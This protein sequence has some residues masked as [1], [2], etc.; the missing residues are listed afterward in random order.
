M[1]IQGINAVLNLN[2]QIAPDVPYSLE[3]AQVS[4]IL[5]K[6][7]SKATE[8]I[9]G[10]IID[11]AAGQAQVLLTPQTLSEGGTYK[12]QVHIVFPDNTVSKSA[13]SAFY[14]AESLQMTTN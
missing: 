11:A 9:P 12:Y 10:Q 8:T 6:P 3:N 14:V 4:I 7:D 2:V 13:I 5:E 1:L